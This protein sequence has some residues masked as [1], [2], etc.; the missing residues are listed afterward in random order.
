[1]GDIGLLGAT[2]QGYGCAGVS[3]VAYGL[4]A[5]EVERY[6]AMLSIYT[7]M[8]R[9]DTFVPESIRVTDRRCLFNLPSL[10][11]PLM[12]LAPRSKRRSTSRDLVSLNHDGR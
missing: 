12:N 8:A 7:V 4:I 2:I 1:M 5:R 11:I 6:T 10:C 3:N 9:P